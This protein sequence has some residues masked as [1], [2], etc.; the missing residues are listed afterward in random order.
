MF[1]FNSKAVEMVVSTAADHDAL[2]GALWTAADRLDWVL[3]ELQRALASAAQRS[4]RYAGEIEAGYMPS[5][6]VYDDFQRLHGNVEAAR[7]HY[8]VILALSGRGA[9]VTEATEGLMAAFAMGRAMR[10]LSGGA[11]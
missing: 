8:R 9:R 11:S 7:E 6:A 2:L 1:K 10:A 5:L 3:D 4:A